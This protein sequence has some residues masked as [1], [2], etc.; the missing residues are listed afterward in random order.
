MKTLPRL[1]LVLWAGLPVRADETAGL[2]VHEWGTFT[3]FAGSRGGPLEWYQPLHDTTPLP[4]FVHRPWSMSKASGT[5]LVRMETPVLYFYP[6]K[7][8]KVRI[9]VA[10][11]GGRLTEWFPGGKAAPF[12]QPYGWKQNGGVDVEGELLPPG[13]TAAAAAV[14]DATGPAGAHYAQAR[15]VPDAWFFRSQPGAGAAPETDRFFFYRGLGNSPP[16]YFASSAGPG[17]ITLAHRGPGGA[18][19]SAYALS[20]QGGRVGWQRLP[21]LGEA[22]PDDARSWDGAVESTLSGPGV[23]LDQGERELTE[24]LVADLQVAGLT[25]AEARAMVATWE[26]LWFREPGDRVLALLP[27]AWVDQALP[28]A[29]TPAPDRLVRVFVGRLEVLSAAREQALVALLDAPASDAPDAAAQARFQGL[30]LGRFAEGALLRAVELQR[31]RT[32]TRF[33]ALRKPPE[34]LQAAK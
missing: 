30:E 24:A 28:L 5:A 2:T 34:V 26:G 23:P 4:G 33:A 1:L 6:P 12:Q 27:R 10:L 13:D 19:G 9:G 16:P 11:A 14:P 17:R 20:V 29:L 18:I 7:P 3:T 8:M 25:A 21:P 15:E 31:A 32:W 22:H